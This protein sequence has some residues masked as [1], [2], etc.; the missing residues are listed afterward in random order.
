MQLALY[1]QSENPWK[2]ILIFQWILPVNT[3]CFRLVCIHCLGYTCIE[4]KWNSSCSFK[5]IKMDLSFFFILLLL[6]LFFILCFLMPML[7]NIHGHEEDSWGLFFIKMQR[8]HY[9]SHHTFLKHNL[10]RLTDSV[11][12]SC[13]GMWKSFN[14]TKHSSI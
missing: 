11:S 6:F 12:L 8:T 7:Y 3:E 2:Y 5:N 10:S 1:H 4:T 14:S 9:L 13:V